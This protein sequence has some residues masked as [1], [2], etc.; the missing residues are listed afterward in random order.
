MGKLSEELPI[1]NVIK[2]EMKKDDK[3]TKD[4]IRDFERRVGRSDSIRFLVEML[5]TW[6]NRYKKLADKQWRSH[7]KAQEEIEQLKAKIEKYEQ[8]EQ[9]LIEE[10]GTKSYEYGI[11]TGET[12]PSETS[13]SNEPNQS[14][15]PCIP[16]KTDE[17]PLEVI[18]LDDDVVY[19][20]KPIDTNEFK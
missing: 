8:A 15:Q 9:R 4:Q 19:N 6:Q 14:N 18:E 13:E 10:F 12:A 7:R 3:F 5:Q 2:R 16:S 20:L 1:I 17:E 11:Y